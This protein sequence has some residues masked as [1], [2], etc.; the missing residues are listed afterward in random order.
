MRPEARDSRAGK[1]VQLVVGASR[2]HCQ[3]VGAFGPVIVVTVMGV[4]PAAVVAAGIGGPALPLAPLPEVEGEANG[5]SVVHRS[6]GTEAATALLRFAATA[7]GLLAG[8][9]GLAAGP[10]AAN[11]VPRHKKLQLGK[12]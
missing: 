12:R 5:A 11:T 8:G 7:F 3:A 10:A 4:Q 6:G 9:G 1:I 2:M